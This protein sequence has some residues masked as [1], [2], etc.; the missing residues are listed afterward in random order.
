MHVVRKHRTTIQILK[1]LIILFQ[2]FR[3]FLVSFMTLVTESEMIKVS[4]LGENLELTH[5]SG[6]DNS[7]LLWLSDTKFIRSHS[8]DRFLHFRLE[9][10]VSYFEGALH[11]TLVFFNGLASLIKKVFEQNV[12]SSSRILDAKRLWWSYCWPLDPAPPFRSILACF[13]IWI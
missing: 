8:H 12:F 2:K 13:S 7:N 11:S 6:F 9:A 1:I 5:F 4:W 3:H 10:S